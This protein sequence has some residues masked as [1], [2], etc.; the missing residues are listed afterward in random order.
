MKEKTQSEQTPALS[1]DHQYSVGNSIPSYTKFSVASDSET[2]I[3]VDF[4]KNFR[5]GSVDPERLFSLGRL[6]KNYLQNRLSGRKPFQKCV[7]EQK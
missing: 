1:A 3:V 6:S 2:F 4:M 7:F 5:P